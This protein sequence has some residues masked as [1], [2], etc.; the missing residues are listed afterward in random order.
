MNDDE[1]T[2]RVVN[3][4]S[5]EPMPGMVKRQC[6]ECRYFFAVPEGSGE[7]RCPDCASFGS[8]PTSANPSCH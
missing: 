8:R 1:A 3:A 7:R 5:W 2:P 4:Q 6:P